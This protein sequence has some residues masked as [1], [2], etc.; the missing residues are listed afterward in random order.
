MATPILA[1]MPVRDSYTFDPAYNTIEVRL[2]G[3]KSRK[4]LDFL[5]GVHMVTPTWIL[6]KT[7]YTKFMGFF[8]ERI[9]QGSREFLAP[10]LTDIAFVMNHRCQLM[11][12]MPKLIQQSG[13]AYFVTATL[14]I[15]PNPCKSF[16]L[17]LQNTGLGPTTGRVLDL[18]SVDYA[19]DTSEF[20]VGRN[21]VITGSRSSASTWGGVVVDLDGTY[22]ISAI[23]SSLS[24][25]LLTPAT[26]NPGWTTLGSLTPT[27]PDVGTGACI[28]VPV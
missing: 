9:Q 19:G 26:V 22:Q 28:L 17:K 3:G 25:D 5:G 8:R 10:L 14:E 11:G 27:N 12:G 2:S 15:T 18:G 21:V 1:Y 4:R 6:N 16:S 7:D 13:D 24:F 23:A 20:P